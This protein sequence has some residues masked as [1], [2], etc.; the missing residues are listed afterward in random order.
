M[1]GACWDYDFRTP[2]AIDCQLVQVSSLCFFVG[3]IFVVSAG[4]SISYRMEKVPFSSVSSGAIFVL[5]A[6]FSVTR[7]DLIL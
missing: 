1:G 3:A 5:E 6:G 2:D 7:L 4:S